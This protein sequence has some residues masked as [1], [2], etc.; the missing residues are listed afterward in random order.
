MLHLELADPG[1][2]LLQDTPVMAVEL[3]MLMWQGG[4][5]AVAVF[6]L[7]CRLPAVARLLCRLLVRQQKAVWAAALHLLTLHN[8]A[9]LATL[10]DVPHPERAAA[11]PLLLLGLL[12]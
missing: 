12:Q 1:L 7:P 8:E 2:Q 3:L 6:W 5:R 9:R 10:C 4:S 11:L